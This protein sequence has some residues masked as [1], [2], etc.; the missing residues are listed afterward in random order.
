MEKELGFFKVANDYL[1]L[2]VPVWETAIAMVPG[3]GRKPCV[4]VG[5]GHSHVSHWAAY[6]QLLLVYYVNS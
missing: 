6:L 1:N 3:G 5:T 2:R 4:A